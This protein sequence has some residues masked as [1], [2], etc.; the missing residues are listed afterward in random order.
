VLFGS[1]LIAA[2]SGIYFLFLP[3]GGF[4]GGR[5]PM[6]NIQI[7]FSR[8]TWDDLHTWSGVIMI[9]V[10]L[11]HLVLHWRWLVSTTRR[12]FKEL[13][14][15]CG[16]INARGRWNLVLDLVVAISF[17]LTA[18]SGI[19][20]LFVTGGRWVADPMIL[21]SRTTWDLIHTWAAVILIAS[22]VIHFAIHWKWITKVTRNLM[23]SASGTGVH[24]QIEPVVVSR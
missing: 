6:Y 24:H 8:S 10:A 3:N 15:Q 16:C 7:L 12:I 20:F 21:F 4:Q 13:S 14:G 5:N 22:A 18:L 11:I 2:L 23:R 17:I 19:Y 1:A 9:A